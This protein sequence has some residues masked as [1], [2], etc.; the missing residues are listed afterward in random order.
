[1]N[2]IEQKDTQLF[3]RVIAARN[4][5]SVTHGRVPTYIVGKMGCEEP[6]AAVAGAVGSGMTADMTFAFCVPT[7]TTIS[8]SGG[9]GE[10]ATTRSAP[11]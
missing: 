6:V 3:F 10:A 5:I 11:S 2:V 7:N 1:M 4:Y 9:T 8:N